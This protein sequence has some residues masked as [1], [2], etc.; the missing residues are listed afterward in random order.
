M[1]HSASAPRHP[2][3]ACLDAI[4]KA[5]ASVRDCDPLYL[6]AAEQAET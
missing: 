1:N 2:L 6:G 5:L 4:E 3:L